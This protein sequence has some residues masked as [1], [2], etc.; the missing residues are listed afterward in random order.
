MDRAPQRLGIVDVVPQAQNRR[1]FRG[2][3]VHHGQDHMAGVEE[4]RD[5]AVDGCDHVV[6]A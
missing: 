4:A 2:V 3:L 5:L 6:L 1:E